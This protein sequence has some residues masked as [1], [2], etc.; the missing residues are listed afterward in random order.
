M[1]KLVFL[2]TSDAKEE[3]SKKLEETLSDIDGLTGYCYF[4]HPRLVSEG[5]EFSIDALLISPEKG[6]VI[7]DYAHRT[8][9]DDYEYRQGCLA[10]QLEYRLRLRRELVDGRRLLPALHVVTFAPYVDDVWRFERVGYPIANTKCLAKVLNKLSWEGAN[11]ELYRQTL[12]AIE[13]MPAFRFLLTKLC[14]I[15]RNLSPEDK[16]RLEQLVGGFNQA[17]DAVNS[18]ELTFLDLVE[19]LKKLDPRNKSRLI[20]LLKHNIS[21]HVEPRWLTMC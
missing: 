14:V 17:I 8:V 9:I 4:G 10:N 15:R 13:D 2:W 3:L 5:L 12:L 19:P 21:P 20:K 1:N 11:E 7:F 16:V 6:I 18:G